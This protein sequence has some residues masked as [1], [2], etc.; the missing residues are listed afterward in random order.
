MRP[1]PTR[2]PDWEDRLSDYLGRHREAVF[3]W[4]RL[5]CVLFAAGAVAAMTG[6]DPAAHLRGRYATKIGAM[7]K[8]HAEGARGV[9]DLASVRFAE[10]GPAFARRG[11]LVLA[12][13]SLGVCIGRVACFLTDGAAGLTAVPIGEWSRAWRIPFGD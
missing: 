2:L 6:E 11:D 10:V 5:D 4:G 3:A 12:Q 13:E 9:A 1:S 8:L 7:R